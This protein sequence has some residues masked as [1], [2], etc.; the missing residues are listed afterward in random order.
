MMHPA[1]PIVLIALLISLLEED[2]PPPK[3]EQPKEKIVLLPDA[4]GKTGALSITTQ[5]G[6]VVLER[7]YAGAD[8]YSQGRVE[9]GEEDAATV[10]KRFAGAL[11]AQPPAPVS[12]TVY[13]IF[14]KDELT[15]ESLAQFGRLKAELAARPAPEIVVTGHT[16]RVG[17]VAYNDA[18]SL[19][20]A[21][22]VREA[23]IA[24]GIRSTQIETAGRGER[25]PAVA[26]ADE[27]AEPRNRRVEITVR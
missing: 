15:A 18:L 10:K 27:V 13:F 4:D 25:E 7:A 6:E 22:M 12:F 19:K 23:L 11:G 17:A 20:R 26:T 8:V 5:S 3:A 9:R 2:K 14:D 16:D 1:I 21:E 24:A